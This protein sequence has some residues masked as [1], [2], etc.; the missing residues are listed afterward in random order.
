MKYALFIQDNPRN[1]HRCGRDRDTSMHQW[2]GGPVDAYQ[3]EVLWEGRTLLGYNEKT[4]LRSGTTNLL[5]VLSYIATQVCPG[6][7]VWYHISD[8]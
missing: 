3:W 6:L 2:M 8:K 4:F 5:I 7:K 1:R